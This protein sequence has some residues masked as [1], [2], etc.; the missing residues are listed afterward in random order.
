MIV[1]IIFAVLFIVEVKFAPRLD[2]TGSN[3]LLWYK[4]RSKY[5]TYILRE[6]IKIF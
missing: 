2:W 4:I 1:F 3:L 6:Y 5:G